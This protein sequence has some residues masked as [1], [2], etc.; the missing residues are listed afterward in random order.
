MLLGL[1]E[2]AGEQVVVRSKRA[3]HENYMSLDDREK[4][5]T[6]ETHQVYVDM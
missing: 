1:T 3:M 2:R 6:D 4:R 5:Y